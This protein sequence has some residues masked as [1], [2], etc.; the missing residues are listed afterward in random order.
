MKKRL[1]WKRTHPAHLTGLSTNNLFGE[2]KDFAAAEEWANKFIAAYP[3]EA[4]GYEV[5]GDIK[6]A[7][8]NLEA[9][10]EAYNNASRI[11]PTLELAAH[12]RG[13]VNSFLGKYR[14]CTRGL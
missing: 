12:K 4:K 11:D 1:N 9:A 13:H 7:Q 8:D 2:P 14:R 3:D 6:R 10:L 5:L